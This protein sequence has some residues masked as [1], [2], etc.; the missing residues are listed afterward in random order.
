MFRQRLALFI[1][2]FVLLILPWLTLK[3]LKA[4]PVGNYIIFNGG[5]LKAQNLTA[6]PPAAF[7]L[8]AWIKPYDISN[9]RQILTIGNIS[10]NKIFYQI[11][12]NGGSLSLSYVFNNSSLRV[13]TSGQLTENV[14]QFIGITISPG[15]TKL[16][17]NGQNV[18][19][20]LGASNLMPI[21]NDIILGSNI[22]SGFTNSS[23]NYYGEIDMLR[24]SM[25]EQNIS[26][27]WQ[28]N[29][30][31]SNLQDD[32]STVILWNFDQSRGELTASDLSEWQITGYLQGGDVKIHYYGV[33]PTPTKFSQFILP[34]LPEIRRIPWPTTQ[35]NPPLPTSSNPQ[36]TWPFNYNYSRENR[37]QLPR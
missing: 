10:T 20:V 2:L 17:I 23:Q 8:E 31:Q 22:P 37:G 4:A 5:Y 35:I 29:L 21:G 11:G 7:S 18:I 12:I 19:S 14:L 13:I 9:K 16:Y 34:T 33:L 6:L 32:Q 1:I 3:P 27:N 30:Y 26:Q 15:A 36:P 24:I 28:N 25:A